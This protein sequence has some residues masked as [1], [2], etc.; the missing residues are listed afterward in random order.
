MLAFLKLRARLF[1]VR[2]FIRN[3]KLARLV[4]HELAARFK[5]LTLKFLIARLLACGKNA[6]LILIRDL[7]L[8][9]VLRRRRARARLIRAIRRRKARARDR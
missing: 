7:Q 6:V 9:R 8:V 4:D 5:D 3:F 1:V 2:E